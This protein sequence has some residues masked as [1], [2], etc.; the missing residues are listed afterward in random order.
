MEKVRV[1]GFVTGVLFSSQPS[2]IA[3]N[4][5][6]HLDQG[7]SASRF[8]YPA[9]LTRSGF[10]RGVFQRSGRELFPHLLW[11]GKLPMPTRD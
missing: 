2:A 11:I 4:P 1:V 8:Q 6:K 10:F 7:L 3:L 9:R 5:W